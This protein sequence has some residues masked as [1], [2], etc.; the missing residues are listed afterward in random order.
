VDPTATGTPAPGPGPG[1]RGGDV[2]L[3]AEK[4]FA[5][6]I[7]NYAQAKVE[8]TPWAGAWWPYGASGIAAGGFAGSSGASPAGKYDAA[9]GGQ[10]SAQL[11]EMHNHGPHVK[12]IQGWWGHCNGWCAAAALFP[13]PRESVTVNGVTFGNADIKALLTE[14]GMAANA[15][16]FGTRVDYGNDYNTPKYTDTVPD[17][18]LL[19][20]T[21]YIG[22]QKHG[23]LI[24][25][26]TGDQIWNQ[27]LAG[28]KIDYPK[29][30]DYLG[31]D[32]R[33]PGVYRILVTS[34]IWWMRD[35][36]PA[37]VV[38]PDFDYPAEDTETVQNRVLKMEVW[39]DG[40]VVFDADGKI[41]SSGNVIVTREGEYFAGGAWMMGEGILSRTPGRIICG[42]PTRCSTTRIRP[43]TS[44]I[45][46][47]TSSGSES[48]FSMAE[49][50]IARQA[51]DRS[52]RR[53][54]LRL[55]QELRQ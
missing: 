33:A 24:D 28:Y 47:S 43:R 32:P 37:N 4:N 52:I 11:W 26:Y 41:T 53:R 50:T 51:R 46:R 42:S 54:P 16:Y 5:F 36:V 1:F 12:G 21:N 49:A 18:Y 7:N 31:A 39:L 9:R 29:K 25:R 20:L 55:R 44:P 3:S 15:D 38:T 27:P 34:T 13:E 19:V 22:R 8:P 17:Q 23:V 10:T 6:L 40:P 35:D 14:A 48:T 2:A 45:P 30:E